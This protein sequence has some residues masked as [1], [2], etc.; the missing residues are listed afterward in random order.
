[1]FWIV[2]IG[3]VALVIYLLCTFDVLGCSIGCLALIL[4]VIV[5]SV[6]MPI[7][8]PLFPPTPT[9]ETKLQEVSA[10]LDKEYESAYNNLFASQRAVYLENIKNNISIKEKVAQNDPQ[11]IELIRNWEMNQARFLIAENHYNFY[12]QCKKDYNSALNDEYVAGSYPKLD[13][14]LNIE[15]TI[16][17][18]FASFEIQ[19]KAKQIVEGVIS[20]RSP[21]IMPL[22]K[23]PLL[24]VDDILG[25]LP[26]SPVNNRI[27]NQC[28]KIIQDFRD[29]VYSKN[30]LLEQK[31][32]EY[33]CYLQLEVID[34]LSNEVNKLDSGFQKKPLNL[35]N[36]YKMQTTE[37]LCKPYLKS[38]DEKMTMLEQPNQPADIIWEQILTFLDDIYSINPTF[39]KENSQ[40]TLKKLGGLLNYYEKSNE[41]GYFII[42]SRFNRY[43]S[44]P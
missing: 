25:D 3:I 40:D 29:K 26:D 33:S 42:R 22:D 23:F 20:S 41:N 38:V 13:Q 1:M 39:L 43:Y 15:E 9:V 12:L 34:K 28:N 31:K 36:Q 17:L 44:T 35:L 18:E 11:T 8:T 10:V 24:S 37:L 21:L 4:V 27:K 32:D 14:L 5:A 6:I 16:G 2:L 30:G 19:N 7:C